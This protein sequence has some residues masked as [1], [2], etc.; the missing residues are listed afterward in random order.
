M[1]SDE[2]FTYVAAFISHCA[3]FTFGLNRNHWEQFIE[4]HMEETA[5]YLAQA[6]PPRS[7]TAMDF[8]RA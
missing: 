2:D 8:R 6:Q 4:K 7:V 5:N 3:V 1:E